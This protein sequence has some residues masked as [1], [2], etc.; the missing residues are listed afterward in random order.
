MQF[1]CPFKATATNHLVWVCINK[2]SF[3]YIYT[4]NSFINNIT[5]SPTIYRRL[6]VSGN[7]GF[8]EYHLNISD[9]RISDEGRYECSVSTSISTIK[10]TVVG[11]HMKTIS[12]VIE[13]TLIKKIVF[14]SFF[15]YFILHS[16]L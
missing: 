14:L 3:L 10:L 4:E 6:A 9:V 5:L 11:K 8:G 7:H 16:V 13:D 12:T 1:K 15:F 2:L